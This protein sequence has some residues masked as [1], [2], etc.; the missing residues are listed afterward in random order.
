MNIKPPRSPCPTVTPQ[1]FDAHPAREFLGAF[2]LHWPLCQPGHLSS[3]GIPF[4][5]AS[6][7]SPQP[8]TMGISEGSPCSR[9]FNDLVGGWGFNPS[10]KYEFV[11]FDDDI[12]EYGKITFMFQT[13]KVTSDMCFSWL[14]FVCKSIP[15]YHL[16]LWLRAEGHSVDVSYHRLNKLGWWACV[17]ILE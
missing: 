15:N 2:W 4:M 14:I 1:H 5:A 9:G 11:N 16:D 13:T 6:M 7:W 17:C 3:M 8:E 10:E 12:P